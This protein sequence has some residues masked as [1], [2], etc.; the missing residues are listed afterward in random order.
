MSTNPIDKNFTPKPTGNL[1]ELFR[2]HLGEEA[3]VPP[4]PLLWDQIDNSL[5][6]RQNETYRRRLTAT[7]WVAAA[8]LLLASLAGTGWWVGRD[9]LLSSNGVAGEGRLA[10]TRP[11]AAAATTAPTAAGRRTAAAPNSTNATT[12]SQGAASNRVPGAGAMAAAGTAAN[13]GGRSA[14]FGPVSSPQNL[15]GRYSP[16]TRDGSRRFQAAQA[17]V[18]S[19]AG[20]GYASRAAQ[21]VSAPDNPLSLGEAPGRRELAAVAAASAA[22]GSVAASVATGGAASSASAGLA[23][24]TPTLAA[25]ALTAP[26]TSALA[27]GQTGALAARATILALAD[28]QLLPTGLVSAPV[29]TE[30]AAIDAH[31][32][33]YSTSYLAGVFNPNINFSRIG[34]EPAN[35]YDRSPAFGA[36]SPALTESAATEYRNNLRPGLSQRLAVLATRHLK[37]HWSLSTGLELSQA[38]ARSASASAFVGE[39]LFDLGQTAHPLQT[40]DFRYR[41]A[42][43]P[44]E[45]RYTNPVKRGWSLYGRL[46]GVVS[47]LLGV[48]SEVAGNPEATRTYSITSAGTPYRR[49]LASVRGGA[50]AQF[51]AGT[52]K[53][54]LSVG[55][56]ADL[57]LVSLNAHPAQPYL[58]Q[59]HPFTIG[60]E[61]AIEFGR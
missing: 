33:H 10:A 29:P 46:G 13:A 7:R 54:A 15:G 30:A 34:I 43:V 12:G 8:S 48:R 3:A 55:P 45:L 22:S 42:N 28:A 19:A 59:S 11:A 32:W 21:V 23:A 36:N 5:L 47:A 60:V 17:A 16:M 53:W 50:G 39:Q 27:V 4:Q 52:G 18:A 51:R 31:R 49:V 56:V 20:P 35:G 41:L 44:A 26:T 57:G 25:A 2:H 38:T 37:G 14:G 40:T 9:A 24:T 61:A 58:A 1:E 6:I